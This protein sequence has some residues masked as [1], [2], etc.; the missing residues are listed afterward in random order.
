MPFYPHKLLSI[1]RVIHI[2]NLVVSSQDRKC[3][4]DRVVWIAL[5][6]TDRD[7]RYHIR[8][9][10]VFIVRFDDFRCDYLIKPH[11]AKS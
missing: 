4:G 2:F 1:L 6:S 7:R 3:H 8:I 10:T 11:D 5:S 9:H